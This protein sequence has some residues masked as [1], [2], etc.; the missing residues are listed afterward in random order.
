MFLGW[1]FSV[2]LKQI[3]TWISDV[4]LARQFIDIFLCAFAFYYNRTIDVSQTNS[5]NQVLLLST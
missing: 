4:C 2:I 3:V 1:G 5:I